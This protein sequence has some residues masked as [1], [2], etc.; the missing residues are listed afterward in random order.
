MKLKTES[1]Y[2]EKNNLKNEIIKNAIYKEM[3][4]ID[5]KFSLSILKYITHITKKRRSFI[6]KNG[7]RIDMTVFDEES[8]RN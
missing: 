7:A 6:M 4:D 1:K 8:I 5:A 3:N 2:I